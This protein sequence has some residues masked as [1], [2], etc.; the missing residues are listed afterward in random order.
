[1]KNQFINALN[2]FFRSHKNMTFQWVCCK[3]GNK[4]IWTKTINL[5]LKCKLAY[6]WNWK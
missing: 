2:L 3:I 4:K 6:D 5:K 1:M